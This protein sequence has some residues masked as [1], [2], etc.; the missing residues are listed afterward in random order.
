MRCFEDIKQKLK[1]GIELPQGR[2]GLVSVSRG[3]FAE[4]QN[5]E[6]GLNR[7]RLLFAKAFYGR[8]PHYKEWIELFHIEEEFF[9][10]PAEDALLSLISQCYRRVF[11]EYYNDFQ[12]LKE[13]KAGIPPEETRLGRKLKGLGYTF[14]RDWYYPEGWM[15]GGY[16]LQA[17]RS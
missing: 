5:Y 1:K 14:F 6:I 11:V 12:T 7:K 2:L 17:E 10:S 13:L 4:E 9:A 8:R 15:E 16:K 3:R